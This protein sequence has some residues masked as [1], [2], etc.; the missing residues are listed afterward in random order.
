MIVFAVFLFCGGI[1]LLSQ[2]GIGGPPLTP[3]D[4]A[5]LF[6]LGFGFILLLGSL[7]TAGFSLVIAATSNPI[8]G[9]VFRAAARQWR[10]RYAEFN[11][12]LLA[13]LILVSLVTIFAFAQFVANV[14]ALAGGF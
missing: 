4:A 6:A 7:A 14:S 11:R 9:A 2:A 12:G 1:P 3:T 8:V 5:L 10:S 13:S